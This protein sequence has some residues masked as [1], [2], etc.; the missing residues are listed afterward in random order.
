MKDFLELL[1]DRERG[2][3]RGIAWAAAGAFALLLLAGLSGRA[4][5]RGAASDKARE[6]KD[7]GNAMKSRAEAKSQRDRWAQAQTDLEE[8]SSFLYPAGQAMSD[9]RV[10]LRQALRDCGLPAGNV[11]YEYSEGKGG[12]G[13]VGARFTVTA[14]YPTLKK[15]LARLDLPGRALVVEKVE[16][17]AQSGGARVKMNIAVAAYHAE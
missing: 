15:L 12:F 13:A 16:F 4:A 17:A 6:A 5:V 9:L 2:I 8:M 1:T 3:L 7:Y 10:E 14:P 11:A